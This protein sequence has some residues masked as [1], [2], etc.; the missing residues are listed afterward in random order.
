MITETTK[1]C[2]GNG[3]DQ[4]Q[5]IVSKAE[6]SSDASRDDGLSVYCK[7]CAAARQRKWKHD[8]TDKVREAK[9]AYRHKQRQQRQQGA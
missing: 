3:I 6:F 1:F 8:N 9:R 2:F 5:H 4:P 7:A